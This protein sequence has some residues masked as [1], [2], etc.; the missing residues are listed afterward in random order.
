MLP[1]VGLEVKQAFQC[2]LLPG[3]HPVAVNHVESQC[4]GYSYF[5]EFCERLYYNCDTWIELPINRVLLHLGVVLI[6]LYYLCRLVFCPVRVLS[7]SRHV[8]LGSGQRGY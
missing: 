2:L 8:L 6:V 5:G 4:F 7:C 1:P 3:A